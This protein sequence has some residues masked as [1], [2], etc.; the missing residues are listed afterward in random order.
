MPPSDPDTS[1]PELS[2]RRKRLLFRAWHRGTK[3]A[4]LLVGNFVS[5][6]VAAFTE[7]ELDE[8][9]GVLELLDVDM[10]DWLSGRL[11]IPAE[12]ETPMLRRMAAACAESGA[13]TAPGM[14][15]GS[16]G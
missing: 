12:H 2:T 6:H 3:E 5:R 15:G 7:A 11:P 14:T 10:A 8:L 4:D 9:E 13:G 16:A 1:A